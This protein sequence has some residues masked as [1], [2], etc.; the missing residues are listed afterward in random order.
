AILQSLGPNGR[1]LALDRDPQ[2]VAHAQE[3]FANEPRFEI[4]RAAFSGLRQ[5]L[6]ERELMNKVSGVLMDI[7]VSSPQ[8]DDADRGFSFLRDG[9]L[10]MRM[11]TDSGVDAATWLRQVDEP[12][13]TRVLREYGEERFAK[14][15]AAAIVARGREA[16]L[17]TTGE[18][19]ALIESVIGRREPGQHPATRSFQ[20]IR[21]AINN[22]LEELD[23][24][25]VQAVDALEPGGRCAVISFHSL[26]DR[27][28]KRYFRDRSQGPK[29]PR[30]LPISEAQRQGTDLKLVGKAIRAS[31]AECADNPRARSAIMRVAEKC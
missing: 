12:T 2:A 15:I 10:D 26:E 16:P 13:L 22:E 27:R 7:G 17:H 1:L 31:K 28:V 19:A 20:A 8:L 29:I 5:V 11:D 23:E 3:R 21:I 14:R 6:E 30:G 25:L 18:L 4:V 24:A 9:P